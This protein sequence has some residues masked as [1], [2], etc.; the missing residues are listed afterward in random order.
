MPS[1]YDPV[2]KGQKWN[3]NGLRCLVQRVAE[4]GS[5]AD[6]RVFPVNYPRAGY[7]PKRMEI[8]FPDGFTLIPEKEEPK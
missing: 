6:L 4:D 8:P 3:W 2:I 7:F 1:K 5:W